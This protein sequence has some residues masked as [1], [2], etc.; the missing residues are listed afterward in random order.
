MCY[1]AVLVQSSRRRH[2]PAVACP[3]VG[4]ASATASVC[5]I[6]STLGRRAKARSPVWIAGA[7]RFVLTLGDE[8]AHR[9][10]RAF[11]RSGGRRA[12]LRVSFLRRVKSLVGS[13]LT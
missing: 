1:P 2:P 13:D 10:R 6:V 5:D 11:A 7:S 3:A 8:Q 4:T 9:Q 12:T